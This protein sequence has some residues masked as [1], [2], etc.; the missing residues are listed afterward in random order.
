MKKKGK[1]KA[2]SLRYVGNGSAV[3]I[4]G[5]MVPTRDLTADEVEKY[6]GAEV[7]LAVR[8][9]GQPLFVEMVGEEPTEEVE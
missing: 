8:Y 9:A 4:D 5:E 7:I 6:G 2:V 3:A 1:R